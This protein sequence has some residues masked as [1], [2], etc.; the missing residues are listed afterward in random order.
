[1]S[2]RDFNFQGGPAGILDSSA[3]VSQPGRVRYEPYRSASHYE[4]GQTIKKDG[5]AVIELAD[6]GVSRRLKVALP[7]YGTLE[8]LGV[9]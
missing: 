2:S 1:M 7:E 8:I 6:Q 4:M 9:E 5:F 3:D